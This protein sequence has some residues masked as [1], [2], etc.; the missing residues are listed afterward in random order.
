MGG[1]PSDA[2]TIPLCVNCHA[3]V[4]AAEGAYT[5]N[6]L[7]NFYQIIRYSVRCGDIIGC[8]IDFSCSVINSDKW[9]LIEFANTVKNGFDSGEFVLK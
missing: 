9:F 2:L 6:Q 3:I 8:N 4:H 5:I 1:K 7:W